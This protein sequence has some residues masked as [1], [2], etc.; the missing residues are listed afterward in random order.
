LTRIVETI[1]DGITIVNQ[2]SQLTFANPAAEQLLN[3]TRSSLTGQPYNDPHWKITDVEG[4]P[5]PP[6]QLA[7]AQVMRSGKAVYNVEY[8]VE[9]TNGRWVI[10]STS[11]APL[12]NAKGEIIGVISSLRDITEQK[13]AEVERIQLLKREKVARRE[14]EAAHTRVS[15]ILES[16]TD[17]FFTVDHDWCFTYVNH[18][19][20]ILFEKSKEE[21]LGHNIWEVF[22]EATDLAFYTE[23]QKAII[24]N[25]A[26]H[27]EALY[28]PLNKWF[29][30]TCYPSQEGLSAYFRDVTDR[31][32]AEMAL[33]ESEEQFRTLSSS[34]F[35]GVIIHE[36]GQIVLANQAAADIVGYPLEEFLQHNI[37]EFI[38]PEDWPVMYEKAATKDIKPYELTGLRRDG[39]RFPVENQTQDIVYKGRQMRLA[40][41]QDITERKK[42]EEAL[43]LSEARLSGIINSATDAI[44]T[45]NSQFRIVVFNKAAEQIF[46]CVADQAIGQTLDKFIPAGSHQLHQQHIENFAGTETNPSRTMSSMLRRLGA[47]RTNGEEFPIEATFSQVEAGGQRLL[48]AIIRDITERQKIEEALAAEQT[49]RENKSKLLRAVL[50]LLPVGVTIMDT[51]GQL[52]ERNIEDR[53]IWGE[54]GPVNQVIDH[55]VSEYKS[56]RVSTGQPLDQ[57]DWAAARALLYGDISLDE[58]LYIESFDGHKKTILNSAVPIRDETGAIT[59]AVSVNVD[60]TERKK[61]E[62]ALRDSEERYRLLNLRLEQRVGERTAQL[63]AANKE[64]ANE[65]SE[66]AR[67]EEELREALQKERELNDLKSRFVS[68]TSH[69][70]RTP[71]S[72]ILATAELL[73]RYNQRWSEE[74]K[75][76]L[77]HRIETATLHMTNMLEDILI[78]GKA[79]SGKL[80]FK[81]VALDMP[82]FCRNMVE[83]IQLGQ[84]LGYLFEFSSQGSAP[85]ARLDEKLLRQ[86]VGNLLSNAVKYS[87]PGSTI[88]LELN[89]QPEGVTLKITDQGIGIPTEDL[90]R[91]FEVFHRAK[92]VGSVQGTGLG[93]T[94]VKRSVDLHE[95]T[96]TINSEIGIGT[97]FTV[98]LPTV[99]QPAK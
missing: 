24:E 59:H 75:L 3:L 50:N 36:N 67:L 52:V 79:E 64:L 33:R 30:A 37:H 96:I 35:E 12:H 93:L 80:E 9:H 53:A 20:Q 89:C 57:L 31:K 77:F 8:A 51:Q 27:F 28:P 40:A 13:W 63:E 73:K 34:S 10:L 90:P 78:I 1:A 56:W 26:V 84:G 95:G 54:I 15:N 81:P 29:E 23:A 85:V 46:G 97:S 68:M 11:A 62:E 69:E 98:W 14:A 44:I 22:P 7:F 16:I 41:F 88:F 43:R 55:P 25:R 91:L 47:R 72:T 2:Q 6:E 45:L 58:E 17:A 18:N 76:E 94:I 92:N 83:E 42:M 99:E 48:T 60:I 21:L 19:A 32:Q 71:L 4:N 86:I 61:A 65:I 74:K 70:F 5:F 87:S 82:Q 39:S 49:Q 66:R 38:A